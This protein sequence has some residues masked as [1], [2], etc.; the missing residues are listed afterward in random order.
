MHTEIKPTVAEAA[1]GT[2]DDALEQFDPVS[3]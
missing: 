3:E 1:S 2:T